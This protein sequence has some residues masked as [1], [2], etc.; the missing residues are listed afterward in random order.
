M[1]QRV[2]TFGLISACNLIRE[3]GHDPEVVLQ[4]AG[5]DPDEINRPGARVAASAILDL[6]SAAATVTK[7]K[8]FGLLWGM[9]NDF[10]RLGPIS[11]LL[12]N[13]DSIRS[14]VEDTALYIHRQN[15]GVRCP[16]VD[17]GP[18]SRVD[19][20]VGVKGRLP[21][22]QYIESLVVSQLPLW[23][24]ML[25]SGWS[26]IEVWFHH[27]AISP[28]DVYAEAFRCEVKFG[29]RANAIVC[30]TT[31]LDRRVTPADHRIKGVV[32]AMLDE[33]MRCASL[34]FVD[35]ARRLVRELLPQGDVTLYAL[36]RYMD[37]EGQ[38]VEEQLELAGKGFRQIVSEVRL[39]VLE[40]AAGIP[41]MD[42]QRLSTLLGFRDAA[43]LNRFIRQNV[44]HMQSDMISNLRRKTSPG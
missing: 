38:E 36:A 23:R 37:L 26:P 43:T 1:K 4:H 21:A 19:F 41:E 28:P 3:L 12:A 2:R 9:Q 40:E 39:E 34:C 32:R 44:R 29:M 33:E 30:E 27:E 17:M 11:T 35:S 7:R 25:G 16:V 13:S 24:Q 10:R 14:A 18:L 6:M 5:L 31:D 22:A 8:D 15:W 42:A 20:E